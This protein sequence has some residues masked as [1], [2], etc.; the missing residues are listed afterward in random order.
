LKSIGALLSDFFFAF[1][2]FMCFRI[3]F[4]ASNSCHGKL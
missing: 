1:M 3:L 2:A 4:E